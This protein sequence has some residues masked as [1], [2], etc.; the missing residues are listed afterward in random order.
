MTEISEPLTLNMR[1]SDGYI[2]EVQG[3]QG[4][5]CFLIM[6]RKDCKYSDADLICILPYKSE[7]MSSTTQERVI[8]LRKK[9]LHQCSITGW[10]TEK[11]TIWRKA[12]CC[13]RFKSSN[14]L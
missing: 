12:E 3:Q 6:V 9:I 8:I 5:P 11:N 10:K 1:L 13:Q 4:Y 14:F 7:Y 2:V